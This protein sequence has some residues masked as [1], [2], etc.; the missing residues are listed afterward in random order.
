M[1]VLATYAMR[2]FADVADSG[3]SR[4][5]QAMEAMDDLTLPEGVNWLEIER[6]KQDAAEHAAG[7]RAVTRSGIVADLLGADS[8]ALELE[9]SLRLAVEP[10]Y[11]MPAFPVES[12]FKT[13][14]A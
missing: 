13:A 9:P 12:I 6:R 3:R 1:K 4:H 5:D 14:D 8:A 7:L 10:A 2:G 11:V